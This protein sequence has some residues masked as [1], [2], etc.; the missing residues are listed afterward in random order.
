MHLLVQRLVHVLVYWSRSGAFIDLSALVCN[1]PRDGFISA[2]LVHLS[3]HWFRST[4]IRVMRLSVHRG[5]IYWSISL[6]LQSSKGSVCFCMYWFIGLD[7]QSSKGCFYFCISGASIGPSVLVYNHPRDA[8]I[9]ALLFVYNDPRDASTGGTLVHVWVYWS[10]S[11]II[12]GMRL[13]RHC[14]CM[15]VLRLQPSK[16]CFYFY[17]VGHLSVYRSRLGLLV[18]SIYHTRSIII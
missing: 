16:G 1:H 13:L 7:L 9:S 10:Q 18:R 15:M 8:S 11:T 12:H 14:R 3:V 5:C 17:T 6:G 4:I 2:L